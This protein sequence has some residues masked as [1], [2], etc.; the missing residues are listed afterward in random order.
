MQENID[1][2]HI[3][4]ENTTQLIEE[5]LFNLITR[6]FPD[7]E[8]NNIEIK[9][10]EVIPELPKLKKDRVKGA[11]YLHKGEIKIWDGERLRCKH[12]KRKDLCKECGG[13]A[14]C[15]HGKHKSRCKECGGSAFCKHDKRKDLCKECGGSA[16]CEHGKI[17][18]YCKECGG[19]AFCKSCKFVT[20]KKKYVSK[21]DKYVK[22]CADCFYKEYPDE[23]KVP[24]RYKRKQHYIHEKIKEIY[25]EDFFQYDKT[26]Q[27]CDGGESSCSR[28]E[29]DWFVDLFRYVLHVECDEGQHIDRESSCESK[30][31]MQLFQDTNNRPMVCIRFNPDKYTNSH[32]EKVK[33]CFTFDEKNNIV[34]DAQEFERRFEILTDKIN[35]YLEIETKPE[36]EVSLEYLFYDGS[37]I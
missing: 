18:A 28:R 29:P 35:E 19:S 26:I 21:E 14:F 16:F 13:S 17:K 2:N 9:T 5:Q 34:V 1:I 7:N 36:K 37:E 31:M 10:D 12:D 3:N 22:L 4:R 25:G 23:K 6:Q 15:K 8:N 32:G 11:K 20:G 24:S 30:R 27:G 33:G